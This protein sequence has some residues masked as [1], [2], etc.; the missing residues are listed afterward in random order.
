MSVTKPVLL[1]CAQPTGGLTIGNYLGAIKN[2]AH[3]LEAYDCFFGIVDLHAITVNYTPSELRKNCISCVAQYIACGLEPSKSSIFVQS[4]VTGHTELAWIL[5]C[6]TPLGELQRM[7]Q[8]KDKAG[9]P[10]S[11]KQDSLLALS[12]SPN[13]IFINSGL[14]M[15]PVLMAADILLY[16]ANSVPVG[17]DQKQHLELCRNLAH[18]FNNKYS[19]TFNV[20]EPYIAK[21]GRRI[22]SLQE[23]SRKMSK[24]DNNTNATIFLLDDENIV[25]K[26]IMSA[27]TDSSTIIELS[28]NKGGITNLLNIYAAFSDCDPE[29]IVLEYKSKGYGDLKKDLADCIIEHLRPV[30]SKYSE[31]IK[32]RTYLESVLKDGAANAQKCAYKTLRKVYKKVGFPSTI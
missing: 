30:R 14:L 20:P 26:K 24:S 6:N 10:P 15:Y 5:S 7:T 13:S 4:H 11:L 8:F 12:E 16:N 29:K 2:W 31:L 28:D 21:Q 23:P 32:D 18:R 9:I 27:V 1:T 19:P 25:R 22:M 3:M 17:S